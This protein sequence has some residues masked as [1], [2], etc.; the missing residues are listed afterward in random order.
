MAMEPLKRSEFLK[1]IAL[2]GAG[3]AIL[4]GPQRALAALSRADD[5]LERAALDGDVAAAHAAAGKI[6]AVARGTSAGTN[7]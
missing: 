4:G 6:L 1:L 7:T 3:V 5:D 2:G